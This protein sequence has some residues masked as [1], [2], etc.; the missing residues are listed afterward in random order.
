MKPRRGADARTHRR[1]VFSAA[2]NAS[3]LSQS[4]QGRAARHIVI[5]R[6]EN[7][8]AGGMCI[9]T[10]RSLKLSGVV[11]CELRL[12]GTRV[13]L[14]FLARVRWVDRRPG[15]HRFRVGLQFIV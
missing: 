1:A 3:Q 6:T 7:V 4:G 10:N 5:G 15:A 8:S 14:P 12:P 9:R 13:H 2:I 11:R